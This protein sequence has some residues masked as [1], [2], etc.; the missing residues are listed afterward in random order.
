[1]ERVINWEAQMTNS[2]LKI[3][4]LNSKINIDVFGDLDEDTN[5]SQIDLSF[6][7][8]IIFNFRGVKKVQSCGVREWIKMVQT[9]S[10][11][12]I[13]TFVNCPKIIVD[14]INMVDGFLPDQ[15]K[16]ESLFIPFYSDITEEEKCLLYHT[17]AIATSLYQTEVL[18]SEGN[19]M[20]LNIN[21]QK[22]FKFLRRQN[23]SM[24]HL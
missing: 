16:V 20:E 4:R 14:T 19:L 1:M 17:K 11:N 18:D 10:G 13:I 24:E 23:Y 7:Q 8:E 5:F 9:I 21:E 22:Y 6:A 15:A 2:N 12:A 3:Q